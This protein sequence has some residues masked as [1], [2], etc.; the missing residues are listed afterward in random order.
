MPFIQ[1]KILG[2][3]TKPSGKDAFR[4]EIAQ[5]TTLEQ[6]LLGLGYRPAHVRFI[7]CTVQGEQRPLGYAPR[8][9]E[10][11][12]LFLPASGG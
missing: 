9:G 6:V 7:I 1:I 12:V 3:L 10:E 5:G 11:V 4:H 2:V 8:A